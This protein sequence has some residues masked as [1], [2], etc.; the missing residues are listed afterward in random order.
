MLAIA[1]RLGSPRATDPLAVEDEDRGGS[2][3]RAACDSAN[4][5]A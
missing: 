3:P 4:G 2:L 1:S 5:V